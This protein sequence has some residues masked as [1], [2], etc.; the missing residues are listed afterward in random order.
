MTKIEELAKQIEGLSFR[1][2]KSLFDLLADTL[3]NLGWFRL[4]NVVFTEDYGDEEDADEE[5]TQK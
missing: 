2:Q 4:N 1:Q 3:D 5:S